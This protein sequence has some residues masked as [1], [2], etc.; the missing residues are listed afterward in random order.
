M[1]TMI[2][3]PNRASRQRGAALFVGLMLLILLALIGIA[4]MQ[5]STLQERMAGNYRTQVLAFQNAE[6]ELRRAEREILRTVNANGVYLADAVNCG[7]SPAALAASGWTPA[8]VSGATQFVTEQ[9][10]CTPGWSTPEVGLIENDK[11]D[12]LYVVAAAATDRPADATAI[13]VIET[14]YI[15]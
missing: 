1:S 9:S 14:V 2:R 13:S 15:P 5:T 7:L 12:P 8:T 10:A 4:G 6:T 3:V 11:I